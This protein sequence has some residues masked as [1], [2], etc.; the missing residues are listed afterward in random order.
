MV[1]IRAYFFLAAAIVTEIFGTS[2]LK[3]SDGLT[4]L[5]PGLV[6]IGAYIASFYFVSQTLTEL[7]IGL[8]YATWSAFGI[9][10]V[11]LIGTVAFDEPVDLVGLVGMTLVIAGII[12]L[13]VYSDAYSPV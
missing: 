8:V 1:D 4:D 6:A 12:L 13:N 11:A 2:A 3:M 9:V 7:P 5:L 10:G